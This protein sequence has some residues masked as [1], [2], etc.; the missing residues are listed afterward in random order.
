MVSMIESRTEERTD[1]GA[2]FGSA[3]LSGATVVCLGFSATFF[4]A[5]TSSRLL[6]ILVLLLAAHSFICPR[7][8]YCREFAFYSVFLA[9]LFLTLLWTPD[10]VLGLNTLFPAVDFLLVQILIGSLFM[11]HDP[12]AVAW[13]CLIGFWS[14]AAIYTSVAGFPFRYPEDFSYNAVAA[15]YLFGLVLTCVFGWLTRARILALVSALLALAHIVATTSIKTNLGI[16][17]AVVVA[18]LCLP[19]RG[20]TNH[21]A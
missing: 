4:D 1:A 16:G 20:G 3:L 14:G 8:F 13:G 9:Y 17:L 12:R 2:A 18:A 5:V 11:F 15:V 21:Q 10:G 6:P 19:R 7:W